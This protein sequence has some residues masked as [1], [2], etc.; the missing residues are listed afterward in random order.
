MKKIIPLSLLII[1]LLADSCVN[2]SKEN[3]TTQDYRPKYHFTPDSN[4]INDA[5]GL[6][7]YDG[8]YHLF[9]QYNPYGITWGHMSW[10]H[11]VSKDLL[12]WQT[13]PVALYD[14][15][16][17]KDNDT[18]MIFSG[19]AVVDKNNTSGFGTLSNPPMVAIYTAFVHA[20]QFA[21]GSFNAKKQNQCLAY[22]IDK[23][24]TW[25][26]YQENPV[27]D[28]ESLEY[29]DPKVFWYEPQKKWIMALS[30]PDRQE[31][32]FYESKNLKDWNYMSRW[33]RAG[34]TA[35]V[36]ECPDLFEIPVEG[37]Q[38]KKWVLLISSGNPQENH[39]GQQ[40]FIGNFDGKKFTPQH[41]YQEPTYVD[42]GKDYFAAVTYNNA[43]EN[44]RILVGW[45]NNWEYANK[46][47]T[48][49]LWRGFYA[50]PR[51]LKL[52]KNGSEYKLIQ[53]P[54]EAL[55]SLKKEELNI[56]NQ[57]VE[58][59]FDLTYKGD[60]YELECTLEPLNSN[61]AGIKILKGDKEQTTLTF[62]T[63][64]NYLTLDRTQ[65]GNVGFSHRFPSIEKAPTTL[66]E[67]KLKLKILVDKC[68]IEVFIN[69]G[70]TTLTEL[71]FPT[72]NKGGIQLFTEG[73]KALFNELKISSIQSTH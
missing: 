6:V 42:F 2:T 41:S 15:K 72:E 49:K 44:K 29:R 62:H 34:N 8:E 33:G 58:N 13:L 3:S 5:N 25:T 57:S 12:H 65:S 51:E 73:G 60:A 40:Y 32:W 16:N 17:I 69:D 19:S 38:E 9:Y 22:S 20:G 54:I 27:L 52:V 70:E 63:K 53:M 47:P 59:T 48:G 11:S 36:W 26:K 55:N 43:P 14:D 67:G 71:V 46:V 30:K 64:E 24:R 50:V 10:G 61:K 56:Q 37:T 31:A 66:K 39:P 45:T 28:I 21:D 23:G 35:R 4:W 68:I 1:L 7:Y 18:S